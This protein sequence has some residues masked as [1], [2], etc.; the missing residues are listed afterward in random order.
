[1]KQS[2]VYRIDLTKIDGEGDFQCPGCGAVISPDDETDDV[3]V[4]LDTKVKGDLLQEL[5]IQCNRCKSKIQLTGF[6]ST[7]ID[8]AT[9]ERDIE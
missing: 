3:Y 7:P 8:E 2:Q 1:M 4:I 9:V 5:L 6:P